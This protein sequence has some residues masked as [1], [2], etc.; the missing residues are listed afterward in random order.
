[1]DHYGNIA[2][3]GGSKILN[4]SVQGLTRF[5]D[6]PNVGDISF[7]N[8]RVWSC[9]EI[10][11]SLPVWVPL[12]QEIDIHEHIQ[13]VAAL[14]WTITHSLNCSRVIAQVFDENGKVVMPDEIDQSLFNVVTIRFGIPFR[15]SALLQR[16]ASSGVAK[17]NVAYTQN[18]L[19]SDTWVVMHNLGFNP[20]ITC[21]VN[22]NV[23][24]PADIVYNSTNLATVTFSA[25][26]SGYVRCV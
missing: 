1:M 2:L 12:S 14:E 16:G 8:K 23:V 9:I 7:V 18:F 10:N 19:N 26:T 22:N 24:Q 17:E 21:I 4:L 25:P 6:N 5:P 20:T 3:K 13:T 15:G 11:G